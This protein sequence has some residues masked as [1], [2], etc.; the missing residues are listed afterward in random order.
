[1]PAAADVLSQWEGVAGGQLPSAATLS[2]SGTRRD[3]A[4]AALQ[5]QSTS[6]THVRFVSAPDF[7]REGMPAAT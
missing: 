5:Q 7:L 2:Q 4:Y 1:M 6:T 3:G